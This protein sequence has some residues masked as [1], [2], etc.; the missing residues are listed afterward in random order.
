MKAEAGALKSYEQ[1]NHDILTLKTVNKNLNTELESLKR[2]QKLKIKTIRDKNKEV[3]KLEVKCDNL[4]SNMR[5]LRVELKSLKTE[6]S[7][8][9]RQKHPRN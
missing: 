2:D 7:K 1:S 9:G 8:F 4:R 3:Q 5:N 6:N